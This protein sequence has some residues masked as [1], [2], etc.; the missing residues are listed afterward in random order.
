MAHTKSQGAV[1]GNRDSVSKRLGL[2]AYGGQTVKPGSIIVRQ[3]GSKMRAGEGVSMGRDF[4]IFSLAN[5]IVSFKTKLG[6]KYV[7]VLS[8]TS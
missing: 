6:K 1:K 5:G 8:K 4:T 2:K 3:K 7:Q